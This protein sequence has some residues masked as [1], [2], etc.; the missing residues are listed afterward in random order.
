MRC[1]KLALE[2]PY[3]SRGDT[4]LAENTEAP[5]T[6]PNQLRKLRAISEE[7]SGLH[8]FAKRSQRY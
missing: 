6:S 2:R 3:P 4:T 7:Q 1:T 5:T 8:Q